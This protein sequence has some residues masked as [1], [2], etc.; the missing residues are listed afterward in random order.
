MTK[1]RVGDSRSLVGAGGVLL[2]LTIAGACAT[3]LSGI[4]EIDAYQA[5]VTTQS[6]AKAVAFINNFPTSPLV[7]DVIES[8]PPDVAIQTCAEIQESARSANACQ[9]ARETVASMPGKRSA[10]TEVAGVSTQPISAATAANSRR[11]DALAE[12]QVATVEATQIDTTSVT[13]GI[14]NGRREGGGVRGGR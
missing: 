13:W 7:G 10:G 9:R 6:S 4:S 1:I 12:V 14:G 2:V 8:L 11:Q 3:N 5:A